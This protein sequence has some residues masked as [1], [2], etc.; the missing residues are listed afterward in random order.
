V[1]KFVSLSARDAT[2]EPAECRA[3]SV[4]LTKP[5]NR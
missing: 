5:L 3:Q 2:S 4:S 1:I